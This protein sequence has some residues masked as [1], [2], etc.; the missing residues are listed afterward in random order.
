MHVAA[1]EVSSLLKLTELIHPASARSRAVLT[2]AACVIVWP[3][4]TEVIRLATGAEDFYGVPFALGAVVV[5]S[6]V[7]GGIAGLAVAV[8]S[9]LF[10]AAVLP[11]T[12]VIDAK[13]ESIWHLFVFS[14]VAVFVSG[15]V[16][17]SRRLKERAES[18]I[19]YKN[20]FLSLMSHEL[21]TP[22]TII[23]SGIR[24]LRLRGDRL[25]HQETVE[26]IDGIEVESG[27]LAQLVDDLITFARIQMGHNGFHQLLP[28]TDLVRRSV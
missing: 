7:G 1:H 4:L 8:L 14:L 6:W 24:L 19:E 11:E 21:R 26:V 15:F 28:M 17:K 18:E 25:S 5:A 10:L 3:L 12:R 23:Y 9:V 16:E 27:R 2:A 22:T 13:A 20:S